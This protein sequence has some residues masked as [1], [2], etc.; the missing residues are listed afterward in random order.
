MKHSDA[1]LLRQLKDTRGPIVGYRG[2]VTERDFSA[3]VIERR[4]AFGYVCDEGE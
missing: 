2:Q 1:S 3:L 4:R